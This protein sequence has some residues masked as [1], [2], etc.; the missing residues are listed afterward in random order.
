MNDVPLIF[1]ISQAAVAENITDWADKSTGEFKRGQ[2]Q[3]RNRISN[4]PNAEFPAE[5]G[6][7]HLYVSYACPWGKS[8]KS[9]ALISR[10]A[11]LMK[12]SERSSCANSK[13]LRRSF[14]IRQSTGKCSRKVSE[15]SFIFI[16]P[17]PSCSA[18]VCRLAF[19]NIR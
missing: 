7:Y 13:V 8:H 18:Y 11:K 17:M 12:P 3:F 4:K 2:S 5:K 10:L 14:P 9:E 6:R 19:R 16:I 1:P 15:S